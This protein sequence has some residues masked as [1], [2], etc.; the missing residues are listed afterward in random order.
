MTKTPSHPAS[1]APP[2]PVRVRLSLGITGHREDN[3]AFAANRSRIEIILSEVLDLISEAVAAEAALPGA[4]S[5]A[6][7]RLHSLLAHGADLLGAEA[8]LSRKWELVSPLPYGLDLNVAINAQPSEADDARAILAGED[9]PSVNVRDRAQ[10]IRAAAAKSRLFELAD[11][12]DH[13]S[14]LFIA[15][16][17][18]PDDP[19]KSSTFAAESSLRAAL[20]GRVMIEQSDLMIAIWDG[21]TRAFAGGTG[22]TV[23]MALETGAPVLWINANA[24]DKW[25][26]LY[27]PESLAGI[28]APSPPEI[29]HVS[30]LQ[31]IV[32]NAVRPIAPSDPDEHEKES[33]HAM[34]DKES[35]RTRS[36]PLWH[37]YRRIEALFGATTMKARFRN[38]RQTYERPDVIATGSGA[39]FMEVARA[40]PDQDATFL[41]NVEVGVMRRFAWADG[42]S[43]YLSDVYRGGMMA[44]FLLAPLAIVGGIAY[45][46]FATSHE[47]WMFT[48]FELSLLCV[49]LAITITGQERRWHGRWFE[50][51][52]VAEYFRHSPLLL[53]LG[54]ARA[55]GRWPRGGETAWPE[56]YARHCLRDIGLP[57]LKVTEEYLRKALVDLLEDHVVHQRDYHVGKAKRLAH[58]HHNL[59]KLSDVM[60][61]L[62]V[63]SVAMYLILKSGGILHAWPKEWAE[64][65]SYVFTFLGVMLPTF[66]GAIAGIRYFGD[67]ERFSAI[68]KVTSDKL[69]VVHIRIRQ[70]LAIPSATI[71]YARVSDLAHATDDIVVSEIESWQ[72]VFSGKHVTVPV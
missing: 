52:R 17:Q 54:V 20:A 21:G 42:V 51:R 37:T 3:P 55:P 19:S 10:R 31:A 12:D 43:A 60:F 40:M 49:I 67:F 41:E 29:D 8:A 44:S 72:A 45:L 56:W 34:L 48:L 38:L 47:K 18:F 5:F 35:W 24:P 11:S 7:T 62:A 14:R 68:S 13:M 22:H 66:G 53:L 59:D 58:A 6:P 50:T 1:V 27:G 30:G 28:H 25:R 57:R 33:T 61:T 32:R 36:N 69:D 15:G 39:H 65:S 2:L 70:L 71:D 23:Q 46:T 4:A 26:I 9:P 64:H 16:L 63:A